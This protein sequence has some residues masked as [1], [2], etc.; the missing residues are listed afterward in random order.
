MQLTC[1]HINAIEHIL[2]N[3]YSNPLVHILQGTD[4]YGWEHHLV[5]MCPFAF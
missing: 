2:R 5:D 4:K 1:E 3:A